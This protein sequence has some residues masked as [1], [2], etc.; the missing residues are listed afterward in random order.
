ML[1]FQKNQDAGSL[2]IPAAFVL[3]IR[4]KKEAKSYHS[5][6]QYAIIHLRLTADYRGLIKFRTRKKLELC[7]ELLQKHLQD[8]VIK[9]MPFTINDK[10]RVSISHSQLIILKGIIRNSDI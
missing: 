5:Q 10:C 8:Q 7:Q 4:G 2:L 9:L 1:V 3:L 6:S